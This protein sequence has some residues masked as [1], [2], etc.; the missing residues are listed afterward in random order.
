VNQKRTLRQRL[1]LASWMS[2][3]FFFAFIRVASAH[4]SGPS[5]LQS[6]SPSTGTLLGGV[7]VTIT[8]TKLYLPESVTFGGVAAT[9]VSS[10]VA[11]IHVVTPAHAVGAVDVAVVNAAGVTTVMTNGY[12][13][14]IAITSSSL[15]AGIPGISYSQTL[16]AEGGV[17][18]YQWSVVSGNLPSG[19]HLDAATGVI[20][21]IPVANYG[22]A[23]F[24]VQAADSSSPKRLSTTSLSIAIDI[25]LK[26]GPIPASLFGITAIDPANW[27]SSSFGAFG[28]GGETTWSYLEPA[29]GEFNW[30]RL[31]AF[32][33]NAK[34]HGVTLYWTNHD[35]PGWAA[36]N[37]ATCSFPQKLPICTSMVANIADWDAFCT[38]LVQRYKGQISMYELWNEPDT[39]DFTGTL[40]DMV[41]LTQHF[42]NA[43]RANDPSALIASPSGLDPGWMAS[44]FA[45][46]G[47]TGIDVVSTHGYLENL[48]NQPEALQAGKATAWHPMMLQYGLGNKPIWDTEGSWGQDA[49][50]GLDPDAEAAFLARFYILHWSAGITKFYWYAWDSPTWGTLWNAGVVNQAG[51][52]YTQIY[53]WMT[54]ATMPRPCTVQ[55]TVYT[56]TLTRPNGYTA[57]AVWDS[58][59]TCTSGGGCPTSNY[60]APKS[61]VQYRDLTGAVTSIQSGQVVLIG[62]KPILLENKNP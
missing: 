7:E 61:F 45:A 17:E 51:V 15:P 43:V 52:A 22:T 20:S 47:P 26:P 37:P 29:K 25:G 39:P 27:P 49:P 41:E 34:A 40:A 35:V 1:S 28:K 3:C 23:T 19:L 57:S 9:V 56:C 14:T 6:V 11:V 5:T 33:A 38:A 31:D 46:G 60:M 50:S 12:T 62:A 48:G 2:A 18:P 8:G 4:I 30:T 10:G 24:T 16:A 54:G 13:Y 44:Y 53:Q 59:R 36:A 32:V 42:Y 55:G 21:G 58:S